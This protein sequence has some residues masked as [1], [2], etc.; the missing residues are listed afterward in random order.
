VCC[1]VCALCEQLL[2]F[3][4]SNT[5]SKV[6]YAASA[7]PGKHTVQL[8]ATKSIYMYVYIITFISVFLLL[9]S[10]QIALKIPN[11]T[12]GL[13][14]LSLLLLLDLQLACSF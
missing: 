7:A 10:R 4:G 5:S 1:V 9:Y 3:D 6:S 8:F 13:G 2:N 14:F 12:M 11:V